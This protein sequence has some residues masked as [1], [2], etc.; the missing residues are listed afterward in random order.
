V[1]PYPE[2]NAW[3]VKAKDIVLAIFAAAVSLAGILIVVVGFVY[4]HAESQPLADD[5]K[6]FKIVAKIGLLPFLICL[7]CAFL[8]V[9]WMSS[10][11]AAVLC[12]I[13]YT[14]YAGMGLTALYGVVAFLF[15]L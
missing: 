15:Y 12:W 7:A 3:E 8:C 9:T 14:F 11:S 2:H 5:R 1:P 4:S 10:S 6:K 13:R